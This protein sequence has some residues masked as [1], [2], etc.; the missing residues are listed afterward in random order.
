VAQ[1]QDGECAF[2]PL[3]FAPNSTIA[4]QVVQFVD[5]YADEVEELSGVSGSA[6]GALCSRHAHKQIPARARA[7]A[8]TCRRE[9]NTHTL[10]VRAYTKR[11]HTLTH[12]CTHGRPERAGASAFSLCVP[13][14]GLD[15]SSSCSAAMNRAAASCNGWLEVRTQ[16]GVCAGAGAGAGASLGAGASAG[17]CAV[18]NQ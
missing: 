10:C 14:A 1:V 16:A 11:T 4:L 5:V 8:H 13:F 6:D 9:S 3:I 12:T 15:C 17:V 2:Q 7:H 18:A